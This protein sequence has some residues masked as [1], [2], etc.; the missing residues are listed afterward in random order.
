MQIL[1]DIPEAE[2]T[3]TDKLSQDRQITRDEL[4]RVALYATSTLRKPSICRIPEMRTHGR[5]RADF[6]LI[7]RKMDWLTRSAC[8]A[9]GKR[10]RTL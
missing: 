6:G 8:A 3:M 5:M 9:S 2:L 4:V 10:T 1:V 7:N